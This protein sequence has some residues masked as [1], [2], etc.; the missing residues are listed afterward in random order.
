M[1]NFPVH[2]IRFCA[3]GQLNTSEKD[4]FAL[5]FTQQNATATEPA[6]HYCHVFRCHTPEGVPVFL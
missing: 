5:A 6:L 4:C 3:R 2:R 1:V